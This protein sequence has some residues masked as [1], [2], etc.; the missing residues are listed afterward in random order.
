MIRL[1]LYKAENKEISRPEFENFNTKV[2]QKEFFDAKIF[3]RSKL[4]FFYSGRRVVVK[5]YLEHLNRKVF[6]QRVRKLLTRIMLQEMVLVRIHSRLRLHAHIRFRFAFYE[7][8]LSSIDV[9]PMKGKDL[10]L[11]Q[12]VPDCRYLWF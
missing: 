2:F 4:N 5:T 1:L 6:L 9:Y 10:I 3:Q 7:K 8:M 11:V 12:L